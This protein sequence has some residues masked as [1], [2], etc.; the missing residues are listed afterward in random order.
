MDGNMI[1][2]YRKEEIN[3]DNNNCKHTKAGPFISLESE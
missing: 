3:H 1:A 2:V